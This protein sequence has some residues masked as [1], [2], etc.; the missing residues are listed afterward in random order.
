VSRLLPIHSFSLLALFALS[1]LTVIAQSS[2]GRGA[3]PKPSGNY[4][5]GRTLL[6]CVDPH[7]TDPVAEDT[8]TKR[9][10]M[11]IVWYPADAAPSATYAPRM[12]DPWASS[13]TDLLYYHRRH[14]DAPL[15]RNQA[16]HA[17][18]DP[19]SHSLANADL[20]KSGS[21]IP[22]P[23]LCSWCWREYRVLQHLHR[24]PGESWL[25]GLRNR[26]HGLGGYNVSRWPQD[27]P[28]RINVQMTRL[29]LLEPLSRFGRGICALR[30]IRLLLGT[31]IGAACSFIAWT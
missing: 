25:C 19:L 26:A 22:G 10:F 3:G 28:F 6:Y 7:R 4:A 5:I 17:I 14:T 27:P 8:A 11:V 2:T 16:E 20:A 24:R 15:T 12:P 18:R 21:K 1:S 30:S 29:G 13:E 23:P 9:E 31:M